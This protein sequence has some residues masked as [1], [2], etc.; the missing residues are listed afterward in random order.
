[1]DPIIARLFSKLQIPRS[2]VDKNLG[3]APAISGLDKTKKNK[4]NV[5]QAFSLYTEN[6]FE[7][8]RSYADVAATA[9]LGT[10]RPYDT[11]LFS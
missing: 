11:T 5:S 2:S 7:V 4:I 3:E 10:S 6:S 8:A 9:S 1:M